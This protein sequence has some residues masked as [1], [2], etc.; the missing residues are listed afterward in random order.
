[1]INKFQETVRTYFIWSDFKK[2]FIL[3]R[4]FVLKYK[5]AYI[6]LFIIL[7]IDIAFTIAFAWFFGN[8]TDAAVSSNLDRLKLLVPIGAI[9]ILVN[10]IS[11]YFFNI[12]ETIAINGVKRDLKS[13]LFSHILRLPSGK[14]TKME[15]GDLFSHFNNDINSIDGVIGSK[16]VEIIRL[17]LIYIAVFLY[18]YQINPLLC[19]V[20]VIASPF[21]IVLGAF[22]GLLLRRNTRRIHTLFGHIN[23]VLNEAFSGLVVIRS[24]TLEKITFHRLA[25]KNNEL[26]DLE[27]SNSK[28]RGWFY[29]TGELLSSFCYLFSLCMGAY[30]VFKGEMTVGSLLIFSN[31]VHYLVNPLTG[32]AS[33]WAGFQRS[34]TAVERLSTVLDL[35]PDSLTLPTYNPAISNITS[36]HF[37]DVSFSYDKNQNVLKNIQLDIPVGKVIALVGSSGAGKSTLL[38]LIQGLYTPDEGHILINDKS[39]SEYLPEELRSTIAYVPQET[40]LFNGTI[41][42]NLQIAHPNITEADMIA[43]CQQAYLHDLIMSLPEGYDTKIGERGIRFSGG[44][45][46]RLAIA[47]AILKNAPILLL[48]EATSALDSETELYVQN[49]LKQLMKGRTTIVI[50]HRL[51]TIQHADMIVVMD[52]GAVLQIGNHKELLKNKGLYEKLYNIQYNRDKNI[53][54]SAVAE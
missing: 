26:Y 40:F 12:F 49:A 31:L 3:L 46:Q 9:L 2:T 44:Q 21:A 36:F 28:L 7:M 29:I 15:S 25:Q 39:T 54:L 22:F 1:M 52:K 41:R 19:I 23:T 43:A 10:M 16:L 32:L 5:K 48:D 53:S 4:P 30:F 20:S 51:S 50:A 13:H 37:Q 38:N 8:L 33:M 14:L 45:K 35:G 17:P 42:E 6:M 24:F 34:A 27:M 47:R 18:L 11:T